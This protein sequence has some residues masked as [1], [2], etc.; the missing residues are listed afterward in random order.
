MPIRAR[1]RLA[2]IREQF[3]PALTLLQDLAIIRT[4]KWHTERDEPELWVEPD[5][6]YMKRIL[7]RRKF[8]PEAITLAEELAKEYG[9]RKSLTFYRIIANTIPYEVIAHARSRAKITISDGN[10]N[11]PAAIFVAALKEVLKMHGHAVPFGRAG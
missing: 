4:P 11:K 5:P 3:A 6:C 9:D 7:G 1:G 8:S 2:R 10:I